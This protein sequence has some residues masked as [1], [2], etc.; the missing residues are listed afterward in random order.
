MSTLSALIFIAMQVEAASARRQIRM[1]KYVQSVS[2]LG[3]KHLMRNTIALMTE[4]WLAYV[5]VVCIFGISSWVFL[6]RYAPTT[7]AFDGFLVNQI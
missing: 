7:A 1:V 5:T 3:N 2:I 6:S 4:S